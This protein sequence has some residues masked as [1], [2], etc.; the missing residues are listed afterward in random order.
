MAMLKT[1][2]DSGE[3]EGTYC[4]NQR[5]SAFKG[6]P[7]AA[8][9]VGDLRWCPPQPVGKWTKVYRAIDFSKIAMQARSPE[10]Y[11]Y[12]KEFYVDL[13]MSED[14]LYLNVFTPA[15]T[16]DEKLPV[17]IWIHGGGFQKGY[18]NEMEIDGETFTKK[19]IVF[20]SINYRLGIFGFLAHKE[21]SDESELGIS[22]NYG[23]WDQ[24]AAIKWVRKNIRA[25]G[26]DPDKI[27]IMGQSAGAMSVQN[28]LVTP[29]TEGDISGAIMQS[30]G[31]LSIFSGISGKDLK[32]MEKY[33][34]SFI[35]KLGCKSIN[36]ARLLSA[37]MLLN[38]TLDCIAEEQNQMKFVPCTDGY[39]LPDSSTKMIKQGKHPKIPCLLG[40]NSNEASS[41]INKEYPSESEF[42]SR[43]RCSFGNSADKI[44]TVLK[45]KPFE[46]IRY[47]IDHEMGINLEAAALAWCDNQIRLAR[48]PVY[49]YQFSRD[50]PDHEPKGAF[51]SGEL[52]YLFGTLR[53]GWRNYTGDDY[54][55]SMK[56]IEYWSNFI[57]TGNPNGSGMLHWT[58][59]TKISTKAMDLNKK[60]E[61]KDIE[62]NRFVQ[63]LK[64]IAL[65]D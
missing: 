59:Y 46:G 15:N 57:K 37:E 48:E 13:P 52:M 38:K 29:L 55:L 63:V 10:G 33:G 34:E 8:P 17:A 50:I 4:G 20:V 61:M 18:S 42:E 11:F 41:Y 32:S 62:T 36:E 21:L 35:K 39:L 60:C 51:H 7:Y 3:I 23:L 24:I 31:G 49:L 25:F 19:G 47:Y 56:I 14:C 26:G 54:E 5:Y 45:T 6:I 58:P 16:Q 2:I 9:P 22:G 12:K 53:Y 65:E 43:I 64:N 30:G 44:L 27:T 40:I 28:L 1:I